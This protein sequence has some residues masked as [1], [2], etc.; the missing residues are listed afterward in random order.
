MNCS[1]HSL[2]S[3]CGEP[4]LPCP[5]LWGPSKA[6]ALWGNDLPHHTRKI[7]ERSAGAHEGRRRRSSC[8]WPL[9]LCFA[10]H[11]RRR[12]RSRAL[13]QERR[14]RRSWALGSTHPER[15]RRSVTKSLVQAGADFVKL[16]RSCWNFHHRRRSCVRPLMSAHGRPWAPTSAD[17]RPN[18]RP[19]AAVQIQTRSV[20]RTIRYAQLPNCTLLYIVTII[21]C[22]NIR[23]LVAPYDMLLQPVTSFGSL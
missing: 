10:A 6:Y 5:T 21:S 7:R 11:E 17:E 22:R 3:S 18:T 13:T 1:L 2:I 14:Q 16:R 9:I 4:D 19:P 15:R 20:M 23:H 12:R 8:C